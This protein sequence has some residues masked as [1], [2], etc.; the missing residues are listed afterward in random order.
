MIGEARSSF[1]ASSG[2]R[3]TN[4]ETRFQQLEYDGARPVF[5][6]RPIDISRS[7]LCP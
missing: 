4:Q 5:F 3:W 2:R 7:T 6:Y 1:S